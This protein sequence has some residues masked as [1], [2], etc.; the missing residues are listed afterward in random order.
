MAVERKYNQQHQ[1][2]QQLRGPGNFDTTLR[3]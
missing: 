2:W 1:E 3:R